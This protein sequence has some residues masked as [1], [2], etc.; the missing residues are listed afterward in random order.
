MQTTEE[1]REPIDATGTEKEEARGQE[2][3]AKGKRP[4]AP[5]NGA[6]WRRIRQ[7]WVQGY[8]I[9]EIAKAHGLSEGAIYSRAS[10]LKWPK[11]AALIPEGRALAKIPDEPRKP[12][13][14]IPEKSVKEAAESA[15]AQAVQAQGMAIQAKV[16]ERIEAWFGTVST[17]ANR[18]QEHITEKTVGN[19]EVEE[20]KSLS[21]SL[22]SLHGTMRQVFGIDGPEGSRVAALITSTPAIA[23]PVIDV[24]SLPEAAPASTPTSSPQ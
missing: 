6:D 4:R 23:C 2:G 24:E 8:A 22:A 9:K 5:R 11:R 21:S 13:V 1:L 20:I 14:E 7:E 10:R 18:L 17:N 15:I 16:R 12:V 19:L 3:E